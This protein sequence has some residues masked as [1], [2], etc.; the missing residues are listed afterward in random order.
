M[1]YDDEAGEVG[2]TLLENITEERTTGYLY[3]NAEQ[4]APQVRDNPP[5]EFFETRT[6]AFWL[7]A[8]WRG[9]LHGAL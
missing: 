2:K 7:D 1:G 5:P 4:M 9:K 6:V 8:Y 3:T